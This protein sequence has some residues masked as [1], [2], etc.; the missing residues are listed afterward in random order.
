[1]GGDEVVQ[2]RF[3]VL[4]STIENHHKSDFC[5]LQRHGYYVHLG[6][7]VSY[8]TSHLN[9]IS[10]QQL[11]IEIVTALMC[12]LVPPK[13]NACEMNSYIFIFIINY[14]LHGIS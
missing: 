11:N 12:E 14:M 2:L 13:H 8:G 3:T 7:V 9:L 1:M 5:I 10:L 6:L 4:K